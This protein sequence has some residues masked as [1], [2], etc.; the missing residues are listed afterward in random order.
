M[1]DAEGHN[2]ALVFV[3]TVI[4]VIIVIGPIT[5]NATIGLG[6]LCPTLGG[7]KGRSKA[8]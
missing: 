1:I 4:V 7:I 8:T 3:F 5:T 6:L 2:D